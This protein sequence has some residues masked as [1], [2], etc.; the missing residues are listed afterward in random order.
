MYWYYT[1]KMPFY[2]KNNG[3]KLCTSCFTWGIVTYICMVRV[4]IGNM[5]QLKIYFFIS[6]YLLGALGICI[7]FHYCG[8]ELV[9]VAFFQASEEDCCGSENENKNHCC[10][11]TYLLV[12]TDDSENLTTYNLPPLVKVQLAHAAIRELNLLAGGFTPRLKTYLPP[13]HAPP[14][15]GLP[16][17]LTNNIWRI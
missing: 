1:L 14:N 17:F 2:H 5:K 8:G 3:V 7:N 9:T 4:V 13:H 6:V 11:D 15:A 10:E 16:I 12:D